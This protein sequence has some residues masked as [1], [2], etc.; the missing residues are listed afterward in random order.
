MSDTSGLDFIPAEP[1]PPSEGIYD[2]LPEDV[3]K[4]VLERSGFKDSEAPVEPAS[5]QEEEPPVE[6]QEEVA[7][8]EAPGGPLFAPEPEKVTEVVAGD[9][10]GSVRLP[11][12]RLLPLALVQEWAD[13]QSRPPV[14]PPP[15][16]ATPA[17][18]LP[19]S[20]PPPFQLPRIT[21]EDLEMAGPVARALLMVA[22]AQA[23]QQAQLRDQYSQLAGQVVERQTRDNQEVANAAATQFQREHNLPDDLMTQIRK[24]VQESD[25]RAYLER[26]PNPYKATEYGLQRAYWD[27]KEARQYEFERQYEARNAATARK[28]KLAGISGSGG[29]G[30]RGT[31]PP[32]E[33]TAEGRK[34][35]AVELARIA[36]NGDQ[37]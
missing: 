9:P 10:E 21:E 12:G 5:P 16:V 35:A 25:L 37:E 18:P 27:S 22:D 7:L 36:M 28:R 1:L 2:S 26:D 30:P 15:P 31:P 24:S 19:A 33:D 20:G 6:P 3:V 32:D 4:S 23:K 8:P 11:D 14:L 13:A 29:S 34:A 17:T